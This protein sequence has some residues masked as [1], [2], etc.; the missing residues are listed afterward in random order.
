MLAKQLLFQKKINFLLMFD[1]SPLSLVF[2]LLTGTLN[3]TITCFY[4][5]NT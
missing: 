1:E 2:F 4:Y 5:R 3:L